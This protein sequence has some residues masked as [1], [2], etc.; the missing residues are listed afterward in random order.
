MPAAPSTVASVSA[1]HGSGG[2][3]LLGGQRWYPL[4]PGHHARP[5]RLLSLSDPVQGTSSEM[6]KTITHPRVLLSKAFLAATL[7]VAACGGSGTASPGRW[8]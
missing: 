2:D 4:P 6:H 3:L 1:P 5:A 7:M 8:R